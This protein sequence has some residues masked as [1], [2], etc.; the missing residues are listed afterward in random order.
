MVVE[1]SEM[2]ESEIKALIENGLADVEVTVTGDG[3]H[4]EAIVIGECFDG[5]SMV[6]QQKMVYATLNE[7]ITS[8]AIHAITIKAYTQ[9]QWKK[10]SQ[11]QVKAE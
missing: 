1:V 6:A 8:G 11:F 4:Y 7:H 9:A 5:Q 10:A 3:S 2:D